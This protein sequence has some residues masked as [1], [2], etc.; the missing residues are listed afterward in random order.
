VRRPA[1]I[2][3]AAFVMLIG[4][5][6]GVRAVRNRP[7]TLRARALPGFALDLPDGDIKQEDKNYRKGQFRIVRRAGVGSVM[8][9]MWEPGGLYDD[10]EVAMDNMGMSAMLREEARA[11]AITPE[12]AIVGRYKTRSWAVRFGRQTSWSTQIVCGARRV[13]LI[14]ISGDAAVEQLHRRVAASFRCRPDAAKER[15][16]GEVPVVFEVGARWFH[17]PSEGHD[18]RI[19]DGRFV[20][21]ARQIDGRILPAEL[22]QFAE[23]ALPGFKFHDRVGDD[24]PFELKE[25][26]ETTRGWMTVR[27]CPEG[28]QLLLMSLGDADGHK[29]ARGLLARAR[30]RRSDEPAQ[31]W[32]DAPREAETN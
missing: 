14:T 23:A 24:W 29:D 28:G 13:T 31:T 17:Q 8:Q 1:W 25:D 9:V 7:P 19:T 2:G 22:R 27:V 30:C 26:G 12:I 21:I 4:T 18:F 3:L 5:V 32:P 16:V 6:W 11:F 10:Q 20:L 15:T